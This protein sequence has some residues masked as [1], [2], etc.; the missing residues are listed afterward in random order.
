V[1]TGVSVSENIPGPHFHNNFRVIAEGQPEDASVRI[2]VTSIDEAFIDTYKIQ[3]LEGRNFSQSFSTDPSQAVLVNETAM[4]LLG[5]NT[6]VGKHIRYAHGEGPFTIIG[7][8]Q[9]THFRSLQHQIDPVIYRYASSYQMQHLSIRISTQ[10]TNQSISFIRDTWQRIIP[11]YPFEYNILQTTFNQSYVNEDR[12]V[13]LIGMFSFVAI[14]LACSGLW[15]LISV[16][17]IQRTKEVGIRKVLGASASQ[18]MLILS[19]EHLALILLANLIAWPLTYFA[20]Q[21]WLEDFAYRIEL[22]PS[23]FLYGALLTLLLALITIS[24]QTLKAGRGN[25]ITSLRYE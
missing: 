6:A 17:V 1:V 10:N 8:L 16:S 19:K 9:D 12:T 15:S 2:A 11:D 5:W 23:S 21:S 18:I 13:Q 7:V 3:L 4:R 14:I 22:G 20:M 25:P 24:Y